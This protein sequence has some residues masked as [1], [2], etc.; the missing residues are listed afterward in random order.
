MPDNSSA[1]R[2]YRAEELEARCLLNADLSADFPLGILQLIPEFWAESRIGSIGD[3]KRWQADARR[4]SG[5][6]T[7]WAAALRSNRS[8]APDGTR[9]P[10][11]GKHG[12][13][14]FSFVTFEKV[15]AV[16]LQSD[17][18]ILVAGTASNPAGDNSRVARSPGST[19]MVRWT[20]RLVQAASSR[21]KILRRSVRHKQ[22]RGGSTGRKDRDRLPHHRQRQ[23]RASISYRRHP[24]KVSRNA[25][26]GRQYPTT[27]S[28]SS[29]PLMGTSW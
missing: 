5:R 24:T 10:A 15:N 26:D 19:A 18:K 8:A 11:F 3:A 29:L 16:A 17:G 23:H 12:H 27:I 25:P 6:W 22:R 9:D 20:H 2:S 7:R 14:E 4:R 28:Q 1:R 21:Q 13:V